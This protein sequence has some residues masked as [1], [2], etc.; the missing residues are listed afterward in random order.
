MLR[1]HYTLIEAKRI[2]N[3][4]GSRKADLEGAA[5]LLDKD[6]VMSPPEAKRIAKMFS[7][8]KTKQMTK[9]KGNKISS[10]LK[11]KLKA[12]ENDEDTKKLLDS[13]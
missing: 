5:D 1:R 13:L 8:K 4:F 2:G 6:T 3:R 9:E 11:D 7:E 12:V 10:I